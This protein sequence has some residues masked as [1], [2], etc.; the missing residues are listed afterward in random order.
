MFN[1][2][3]NAQIEL[4]I[5]VVVIKRIKKNTLEITLIWFTLFLTIRLIFGGDF[6]H[7]IVAGSD[8]YDSCNFEHGII[9][10][11]GQG[12]DGQFFYRYALNPFSIEYPGIKVDLPPYRHQRITYPLLAWLLSF[13]NPGLVPASL[14]I[15][16]LLALFG[17]SVFLLKIFK[18]YKIN[19][20]N[21][22]TFV[23]LPGIYLSTSRDLS[24]VVELFFLL[25][26]FYYLINDKIR[27]F[28]LFSLLGLLTRETG[29]ILYFPLVLWYFYKNFKLKRISS[30]LVF[31]PIGLMFLW[32]LF[33][34]GIYPNYSVPKQNLA[35]PFMGIINSISINVHPVTTKD[36]IESIVWFIHLTWTFTLFAKTVSLIFEKRDWFKDP[37]PVIILSGVSFSTIFSSAIYIDDWAFV[38]ILSPLCLMCLIYLLKH[39]KV[40]KFLLYSAVPIFAFTILRLWIRV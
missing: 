6:S 36:W 3:K 16:N 29:V 26:S 20:S 34:D 19:S 18:T 11:A 39:G 38:R 1:N 7:F 32:K 40:P 9:I 10:K 14:V 12:Y 13:N 4:Y 30:L 15:I 8:Y 27:Y 23:L 35:F 22:I 31:L 17:C 33:L 28:L 2:N 21:L 37:I 24:E 5:F 25:A